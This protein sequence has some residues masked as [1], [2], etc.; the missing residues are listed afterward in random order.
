MVD[1]RVVE[2]LV[3]G[4]GG[5][6]QARAAPAAAADDLRAEVDVGEA[7]EDDDQQRRVVGEVLAVE[8]GDLVHRA[9]ARVRE[10]GVDA[11][12]AVRGRL[13]DVLVMT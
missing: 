1:P 3:E 13:E 11:D 9:K 7:G 2:V 10:E 6:R 4:E 12:V 5:R 8:D